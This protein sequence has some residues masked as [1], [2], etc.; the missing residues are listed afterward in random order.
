MTTGEFPFGEDGSGIARML[1]RIQAGGTGIDWEADS[2]G[3][4][5]ALS[6]ALKALLQGMLTSD[7]AGRLDLKDVTAS[8]WMQADDGYDVALSATSVTE[9]VVQRQAS[10]DEGGGF[11]A[12]EPLETPF[13][14]LFSRT[15]LVSPVGGVDG[16]D[17]GLDLEP[18]SEEPELA[19][20][21]H[22]QGPVGDVQSGYKRAT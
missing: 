5:R 2:R 13:E 14:R 22:F 7:P 21:Q 1:R 3:R 4:K 10:R 6:S 8:E 20:F 19:L 11:H 16:F 15:P 9:Q 17:I 18:N 12:I